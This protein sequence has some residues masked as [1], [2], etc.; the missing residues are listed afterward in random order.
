MP[1]QPAP[2]TTL[3]LIEEDFIVNDHGSIVLLRP[4]SAAAKDWVG[5]HFTDDAQ[6][7]GP[8]VAIEANYFLD[9]FEAIVAENLSTI[10]L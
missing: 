1:R 2:T 8:A 3:V 6:W 10:L 4:V 9:I 5:E 7:H